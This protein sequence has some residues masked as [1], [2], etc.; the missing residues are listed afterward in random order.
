MKRDKE[1]IKKK[2]EDGEWKWRWER[3]FLLM[4]VEEESG[5]SSAW[6]QIATG[7]GDFFF[8]PFG[9]SGRFFLVH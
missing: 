2:M 8:P 7:D 1:G 5:S 4:G 6:R 3:F 9:P